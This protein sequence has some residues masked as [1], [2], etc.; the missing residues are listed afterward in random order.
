MRSGADPYFD[1]LCITINNR[2]YIELARAL[3]S[4]E[5]RAK[6]PS[7]Q[8][9]GMDGMQLRVEFMEKHGALGSS[10]NRGPCTMLEFLIGIA[11]HMSFLMYGN[12]SDHRTAY[13]FWVLIKNI[14]LY[15]CTDEAWYSID[16]MFYVED[17]VDRILNR[18]YDW[19]GKGGLFPLRNPQEDQRGV[20]IWYQMHS[21]LGE[22]SELDLDM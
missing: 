5:F 2:D 21:W 1:W 14:G 4:R 8:N 15:H 18:Q 3:H 19:T 10:T 7:D 11:K 6:L 13:Y 20:E 16:G 17:A 12:S 9:R 22:N